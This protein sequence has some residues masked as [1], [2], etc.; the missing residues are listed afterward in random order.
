MEHE[1]AA[2]FEQFTAGGGAAAAH[3]AA[4]DVKEE[5][6]MR[7]SGGGSDSDEFAEFKC[8]FVAARVCV[9]RAGKL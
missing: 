6:E 7:E 8:A 9:L 2:E 5:D 1:S 3:R 4:N